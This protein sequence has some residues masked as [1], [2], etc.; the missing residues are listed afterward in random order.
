MYSEY[1]SSDMECTSCFTSNS[2]LACDE[3]VLLAD[4]RCMDLR[5][6]L[7]AIFSTGKM[8]VGIRQIAS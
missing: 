5:S 8:N 7:L 6:R 4:C 3:H 2:P 1:R